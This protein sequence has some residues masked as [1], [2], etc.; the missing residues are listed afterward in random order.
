MAVTLWSLHSGTEVSGV[1][2]LLATPPTRRL[3]FFSK[4]VSEGNGS[5]IPFFACGKQMHNRVGLHEA[6]GG[7]E[8]D[9]FLKLL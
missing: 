3:N 1:D 6:R 8:L 7:H 5:C 2:T 9:V 4:T